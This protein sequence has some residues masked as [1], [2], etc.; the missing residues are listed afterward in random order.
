MIMFLRII[1]TFMSEEIKYNKMKQ[2]KPS[3]RMKLI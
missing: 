1:N 3:E 2:I